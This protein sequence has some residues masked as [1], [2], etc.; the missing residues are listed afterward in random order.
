[1]DFEYKGYFL[2]MVVFPG[3]LFLFSCFE[4]FKDVIQIIKDFKNGCLDI[5]LSRIIGI[6][7]FSL[8]FYV[9][10][11][12]LIHGGISLIGEKKNDAA[13]LTG[14][15]EEVIPFN[16][17]DGQKYYCNGRLSGGRII[18]DGVGYTIMDITPFSEGD[19]ISFKYLPKSKVILSIDDWQDKE[20]EFF[21]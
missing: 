9:S 1:M 10:L 3:I 6:I 13:K 8:F 12:P 19:I 11:N 15:I 4:V 16:L 7:V 21:S 14:T 2:V 18:V 5:I 20:T 17:Y